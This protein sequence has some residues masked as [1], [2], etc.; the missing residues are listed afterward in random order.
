ML[1]IFFVLLT[2]FIIWALWGAEQLSF[3]AN[4]AIT[5]HAMTGVNAFLLSLINLWVFL[6][7][8]LGIVGLIYFGGSN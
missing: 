5:T 8:I 7:F 3:W 1:A 6:G 2:T 4:Y